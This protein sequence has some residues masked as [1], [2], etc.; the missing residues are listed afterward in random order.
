MAIKG[1]VPDTYGVDFRDEINRTQ[2]ETSLS[3]SLFHRAVIAVGVILLFLMMVPMAV[4]LWTQSQI[5]RMDEKLL[6]NGTQYTE[7]RALE[8]QVTALENQMLGKSGG[9]SRSDVSRVVYRLASLTPEKV[10]LYRLSLG[11]DKEADN[12]I[13][14]SGFAESNES[15]TQ[16]LRQL[17]RSDL[18]QKIGLKRS[19]VPHAIEHA[20][21]VTNLVRSPVLFEMIGVIRK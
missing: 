20:T 17:E 16:Y 18:F 5:D 1:F 14:L 3:R 7:V 10:W 12:K 21:G 13:Q 6:S 8:N 15:V 2:T 9:L 4:S 19:G 11:G